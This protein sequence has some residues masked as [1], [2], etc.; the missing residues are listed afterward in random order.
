MKVHRLLSAASGALALTAAVVAQQ[1][2]P[3]FELPQVGSAATPPAAPAATPAAAPAPAA[4]AVT[5]TEAQMMEVFGYM[6][7]VRNNLGD[8]EF[9]PANVEAIAKGMTMA[10]QGKQPSYD[11]QQIGPQLQ[12]LLKKRQD[13]LLLKVRNANLSAAAGFFTQLE[14]ENKN[15]KQFPSGLRYEVV[16]EGK[17]AVAKPGQVARIHLIG[18]FMN[19]QVF[20]NTR[21]APEGQTADP[22]E[23]LVQEGANIPAIVEALTKMPVGSKWRLYVP[24]HLAFGDDGAPQ[25]GIPPAATLLFELEVFSVADAPKAPEGAKK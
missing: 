2:A 4:P 19:G 23:I 17:G 18:A 22:A 11:A 16:T 7:A 10:V 9:T 24:P 21:V 15:V 3:K 13:A 1:N 6:L 12:E 14:K 20:E 5:F 25:V 8:L